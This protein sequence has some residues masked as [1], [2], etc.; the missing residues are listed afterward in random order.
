MN[1]TSY[2]FLFGFLPL[3]FLAYCCCPKQSRYLLLLTGNCVFYGLL[4]PRAL[5]VLWAVVGLSFVAGKIIFVINH[6]RVWLVGS[7]VLL[8]G[9]LG[10]FKYAYFGLEIA[11]GLFGTTELLYGWE[12]LLPIGLSFYVFN[13]LAYVADIYSQKAEPEPNFLRFASGMTFF[14][15]LLNGPLLRYS[16]IGSQL[17]TPEVSGHQIQD[18]IRRFI[19]G[20]CKKVIIADAF[21]PLVRECFAVEASSLDIWFGAFVY[22][23][24]LYFDFSG[25]SDMAIGLALIF[26]IHLPENFNQPYAAKSITE[27]WQRWHMSLSAFL[28]QYVYIG[29]GG[30]RCG[31]LRTYLHLLLTM[32]IGGLW[33]GANWTFVFWGAWNGGLLLLER[34]LGVKLK[35]PPPPV[36]Y[37]ITKMFLLVMLGRLFFIAPDLTTAF[38]YF[39]ALTGEHGWWLGSNVVLLLTPERLLLLVVAV[40]LSFPWLTWLSPNRVVPLGLL[41]NRAYLALLLPLFWLAI[42]LAAARQAV[43]FLY[44]RF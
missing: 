11:S 38:S 41:A 12:I 35:R 36:W 7:V 34:W 39:A 6:K 16:S 5:M 18:G 33:H 13:A 44:Y 2:A 22:S 24:Q 4:D 9:I 30:N 40:L 42:G 20:F 27:F 21:A 25:Y 31:E 28:K 8:L 3:M 37:G 1:F 17:Q 14:A 10:F 26:G 15:S 43:P 23:L 29:L 32:L 19:L